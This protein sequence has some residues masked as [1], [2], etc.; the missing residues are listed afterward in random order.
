MLMRLPCMGIDLVVKV[1]C[2]Y[3]S[4]REFQTLAKSKG[5]VVR[6]GLK[7]AGGKI[8]GLRT[9]TAYKACM[10]D[11]SAQKDEIRS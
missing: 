5:V 7:E 11:E 1:H 2:E 3:S 6:Q 4:E 10:M 9:E 8:A